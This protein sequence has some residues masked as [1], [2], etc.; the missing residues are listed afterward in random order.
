MNKWRQ[1]RW[2]QNDW[3]PCTWI[4]W[5]SLYKSE[6]I[7][8]WT[9]CILL[10]QGSKSQQC[11][12]ETLVISETIWHLQLRSHTN[13]TIQLGYLRGWNNRICKSGVFQ[14]SNEWKRLRMPATYNG[15]QG[16]E[17]HGNGKPKL[18]TVVT[19]FCQNRDRNWM[20]EQIVTS[21]IKKVDRQ[22]ATAAQFSEELEGVRGQS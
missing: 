11:P 4:P 1:G 6:W 13:C 15:I 21:W 7:N 18:A 17:A 8:T 2:T 14:L 3:R 10:V 16:L 22:N 19:H 20:C 5:E 12:N 9:S